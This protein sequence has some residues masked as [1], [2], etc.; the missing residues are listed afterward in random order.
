MVEDRAGQFR[1]LKRDRR[2][3]R[4]GRNDGIEALPATLLMR[5]PNLYSIE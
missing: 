3:E 1:I 5:V 2:Q 4:R